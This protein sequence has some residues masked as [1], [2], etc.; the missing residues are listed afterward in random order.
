MTEKTKLKLVEGEVMG[1]ISKED[2]EEYIARKNTI[3]LIAKLDGVVNDVQVRAK[4]IERFVFIAMV[5][6]FM[7][8]ALIVTFL[9]SLIINFNLNAQM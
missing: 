5:L 2:A 9:I 1:M 7:T 6:N 3:Q 4:S 8:C